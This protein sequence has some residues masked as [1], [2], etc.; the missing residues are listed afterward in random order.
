M[1]A[2]RSIDAAPW[3]ERCEVAMAS[4]ERSE[5]TSEHMAWTEGA[6]LAI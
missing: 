6:T 5:S 1:S 4:P 2:K 3:T